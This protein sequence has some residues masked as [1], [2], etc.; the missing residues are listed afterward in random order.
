MN[1]TFFLGSSGPSG[2]KTDFG[3]IINKPEYYTYILKGGPGTGKS[4]LM[5]KIASGCGE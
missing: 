1:N 3:K 5:K 2:F 4:T